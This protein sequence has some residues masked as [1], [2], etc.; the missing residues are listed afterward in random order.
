MTFAGEKKCMPIDILRPVAS[1]RAIS[2]ISSVEVLVASTAPGFATRS[3]VAKILRFS[4][5]ALEHGFDDHV[6]IAQILVVE[7][8]A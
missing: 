5:H 7:R 6:C 3:S 1:P 2:A 8:G 4:V